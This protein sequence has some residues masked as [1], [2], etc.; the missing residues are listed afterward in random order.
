MCG[1]YD[2]YFLVV[3]CT[4]EAMVMSSVHNQLMR[5]PWKCKDLPKLLPVNRNNIS[6]LNTYFKSVHS[7]TM[8]ILRNI[9]C[10]EVKN[11]SEALFMSALGFARERRGG[12]R[13]CCCL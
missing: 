9:G 8:A 2:V 4:S 12:G 6:S 10:W 1:V 13:G 11:L 7:K 5:L 3:I